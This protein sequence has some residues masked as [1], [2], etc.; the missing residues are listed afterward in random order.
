MEAA[1]RGLHGFK[2]A[3]G[4]QESTGS[5]RLLGGVWYCFD[6]LIVLI[7]LLA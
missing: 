3:E 6:R 4:V 2:G 5:Y 7:I 1:G